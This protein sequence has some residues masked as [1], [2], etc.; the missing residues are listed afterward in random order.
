M[1]TRAKGLPIAGE[2]WERR[3]TIEDETIVTRFVVLERGGGDYW[4]LRVHVVGVGE[5]FWVDSAYWFSK[6]QLRY[7]GSADPVYRKKLGLL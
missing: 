3:T 5:I 4:S 7:V 1:P 2:I 6:G